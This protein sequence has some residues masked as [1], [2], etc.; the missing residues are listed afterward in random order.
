MIR[1]EHLNFGP[2]QQVGQFHEL[3][4]RQYAEQRLPN[5]TEQD[6]AELI[7]KIREQKEQEPTD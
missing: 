6:K 1:R 7:A 3:L 5:P 2:P 4:G